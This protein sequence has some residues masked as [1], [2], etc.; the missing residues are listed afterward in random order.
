MSAQRRTVEVAR[1]KPSE[2]ELK[3]IANQ[4]DADGFAAA[5]TAY[6]ERIDGAHQA[7]EDAHQAMNHLQYLDSAA[8]RAAREHPD[9]VGDYPNGIDHSQDRGIALASWLVQQGWTPPASLPGLVVREGG[10]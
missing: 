8:A 7:E 6:R 5:A 9:G 10:E 1:P 3:R 2:S 4:L